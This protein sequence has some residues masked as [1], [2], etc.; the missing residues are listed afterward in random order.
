M[1]SGSNEDPRASPGRGCRPRIGAVLGLSVC[2]P[3]A[4]SGCSSAAAPDARAAA[5]AFATVGPEA[6]CDLL[7]PET[8]RTLLMEEETSCAEAVA[9]LPLGTGEVLSAEVWG[10]EALV[11]MTDDTLF[12]TRV[13]SEW[14]VSA[15]GCEPRPERPYVCQL[16][17]S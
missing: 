14:R 6:R 12:L 4:L 15:A 7:A 5:A 16:E 3:V 9:A 8:L 2:L 13:D 1:G 17:G 11:R 10:D